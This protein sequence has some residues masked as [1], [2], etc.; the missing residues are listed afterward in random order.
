MLNRSN[1][2]FYQAYCVEYIKS[3]NIAAI[4]LDCGLGKTVTSLTAIN[5]LMFDSFEVQRVLVV[6]PLRVGSVWVNEMHRWEHLQKLQYSVAIGTESERLTALNRQAD[7]Y[8]I[9]NFA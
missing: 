3:N 8:I 6:C 1:L 2:H 7:I 4:F 9:L 5:E